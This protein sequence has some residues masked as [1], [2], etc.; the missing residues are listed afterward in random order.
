[1]W[2]AIAFGYLL[3]RGS[4]QREPEPAGDVPGY[5]SWVAVAVVPT[6]LCLPLLWIFWGFVP[7]VVFWFTCAICL[8]VIGAGGVGA[9]HRDRRP[10]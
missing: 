6:L 7:L 8:A 10:V 5:G 2:L 3:G 9:V 4:G 1:V